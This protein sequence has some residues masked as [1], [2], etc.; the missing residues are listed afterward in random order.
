MARDD[1]R[2]DRGDGR[3]FTRPDLLDTIETYH[4]GFVPLIVPVTLL[5][6]YVRKFDQPYLKRQYYLE[7]HPIELMLRNHV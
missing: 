2:R 1:V 4:R 3:Q 6:H 5:K 7:P